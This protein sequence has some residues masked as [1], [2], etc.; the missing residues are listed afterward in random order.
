MKHHFRIR[1]FSKLYKLYKMGKILYP[2]VGQCKCGFQCM[3]PQWSGVLYSAAK[4]L[5]KAEGQ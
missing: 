4:A 2:W 1:K 5:L 3:A